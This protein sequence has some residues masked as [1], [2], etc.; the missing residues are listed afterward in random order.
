MI[1]KRNLGVIYYYS[2]VCY[3]YDHLLI[4]LSKEFLYDDFV[5]ADNVLLII[6]KRS[7]SS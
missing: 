4:V 6:F 7:L 3:S 2:H 5:H 1:K